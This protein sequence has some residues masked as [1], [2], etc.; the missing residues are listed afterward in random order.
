MWVCP[1]FNDLSWFCF[2]CGSWFLILCFLEI[3]WF[4][5]PSLPLSSKTIL[6]TRLQTLDTYFSGTHRQ[7]YSSST[8]G[9]VYGNEIKISLLAVH[10][11]VIMRSICCAL[12]EAPALTEHI[13]LLANFVSPARLSLFGELKGM[14]K[15]MATMVILKTSCVGKKSSMFS[16]L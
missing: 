11:S 14:L 15:R 1:G 9:W 4:F 6:Q 12:H 10:L 16:Y 13:I 8:L 7:G 3:V 2:A 5:S